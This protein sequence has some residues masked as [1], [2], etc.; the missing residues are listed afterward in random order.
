[1]PASTALTRRSA[2][3]S[4]EGRGQTSGSHSSAL[5]AAAPASCYHCG[6]P[7]PA[8][9]QFAAVLQG[10]RRPM[11]CAGCQAVAEAI[12][13][14]GLASYYRS[15]T[16]YAPRV[17]ESQPVDVALYDFPEVQTGLS[18][19]TG[20]E[21]HEALLM[22]EGITCAACVWLNERRVSCLPGVMDV[23]A[24]YATRRMRVR[25][26]EGDIKLSA[27]LAAVA[28][29]GYRAWPVASLPAD[30]T[31]R[32]ETRSAWWRL[33][34]AGFGM[35]QVMMY[36]VP[37]YLDREGSM[38][39]DI[40]TLMRLASFV[41]TVPVVFYSAAPFLTGAWRDLKL[42]RLGMDVS[43][44][45]GIA[46]AFAAS[47]F[48][49]FTGRGEV[50][51]DSITMFIF[52][53]LCA[54][55]LEMRARHK[56]AAGL[57]YLDKA[58]PPAAHRLSAYPSLDVE[59]VP[60]AR[61]QRGDRVLVRPGEVF[62]ADGKV[63]RGETESDESLL[64]GESDPVHKAEGAAITGGA[65]N[66]VSP[67]VVE[68]E[69]A[70]EA[71]RVS[72]IRR[73]VERAAAQRP[74]LVQAT[75][76]I[77]GG[78]VAAVLA[79]AAAS[80]LFWLYRDPG[81]AVWVAVAVLVVSCPCAL[82]LATPAALTVAVGR[83]ARRGVVATR[84]H[85]IETLSRVTH[86]VFDKTGTLTEGRP[87]L[88]D[89][90]VL[91]TA[92]ADESRV[93]AAALEQ[94]SEHPIAAA[95]LDA[96]PPRGSPE[97]SERVRNVPGAGIEAEIG[98]VRYRIGSERFVAELAGPPPRCAAGSREGATCAWLGRT[99]EW[100]ARFELADRL[101]PQAAEVVRRLRATGK[102][103]LIMSG[104]ALPAVSATA[105]RLGIERFEAGLAPEE[106]H[107]RVLA[108]EAQGAV[109]A[110]VGDGVNDAPVLAQAHLSI[111]M[112]SGAVLSQQHADVVLLS[113]DLAGLLDALDIGRRTW[114][115][116]RQNLA[117]ALAYNAVM[118]PL[119]AAGWVTPWLAGI[120][121]GA[122]SLL[123]VLNASRLMRVR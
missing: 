97:I 21:Q 65:V 32:R 29:I 56:A 98:G 13:G 22:L 58:L 72:V 86:V 49:T 75:D 46:V 16:A 95:L 2:P 26:R 24:N 81:R 94:G 6:L 74:E 80:A 39:D 66:R 82:A 73:L 20:D 28:E 35:M 38:S 104:D 8:R 30:E 102:E 10:Q 100:L 9:T 48:A 69:R 17:Q 117:W 50:Y 67:V 106:K 57:E 71:A 25:W 119:A 31:R 44:A 18:L 42:R 101:R 90:L 51:F 40:G 45:L 91:G 15:R 110:M 84:G 93:L 36:A 19:A 53:V 27:I 111:A 34:V 3:L 1:V 92:S 60:A 59:T 52:F 115:I 118:L 79:V 96:L 83:L 62:P 55:A 78:F 109:V 89:T 33:F 123:V 11:C 103:V 105:R 47:T 63:V 76:R 116:V 99:G 87:A 70:G 112:G 120:G 85:A 122:S 4:S 121:M 5:P 88:V 54:R 43:V 41:L 61:L 113:G 68:V 7:V 23:Q 107:A 64:T 37:G 77:A 12:A 14:S 114:R 108:L